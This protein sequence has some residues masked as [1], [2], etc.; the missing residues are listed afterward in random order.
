MD[1]KK[2]KHKG[3][4]LVGHYLL[5]AIV[6][7]GLVT[8]YIFKS[9]IEYYFSTMNPNI[10]PTDS[11]IATLNSVWQF[12]P[13]IIESIEIAALTFA[14]VWITNLLLRS[15]IGITFKGKT[16]F[17][18][19]VSIIKWIIILVGVF[20]ILA[21]CG[22]N[23]SALLISAGVITLVVG[24]SA[25]SLISDI[26]AG[27][28]IVIEGE[29]LIDDI[30][31]IDGWRGKIKSIG[32]RTTSIQDIGGNIKIINNS[33]IASVINLTNL[34]SL[35]KV[36]IYVASNENLK[37]VEEL[38]ISYFPL[39]NEKLS[40]FSKIGTMVYKGVTGIDSNGMAMLFA[41]ECLEEDLF[42]IER[43][44]Y[45]EF[46]YI[47]DEHNISGTEP[48]V[49]FD[50]TTAL[51][52]AVEE[53]AAISRPKEEVVSPK[54]EIEVKEKPIVETGKDSPLVEQE[55]HK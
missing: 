2:V 1:Q 31:V 30:V 41:V 43:L 11:S 14:F 20:W 32:V 23:V 52:K 26:L 24:L 29:Y 12:I 22:I 37:Q 18:V 55:N 36:T 40:A 39:I 10:V 38:F 49:L 25:Q 34:K 5:I 33:K 17:K 27:L 16:L 8:A 46:K 44:L 21:V 4:R 51:E 48:L 42:D 6:I 7:G 45:R 50:R 3:L 47:M 13:K 15:N 19:I 9:Q 28:F 35:A 54:V 53:N